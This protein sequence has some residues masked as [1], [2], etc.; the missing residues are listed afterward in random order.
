MTTIFPSIDMLSV[1]GLCCRTRSDLAI[2]G[3]QSLQGKMLIIDTNT[4]VQIF[5][6]DLNQEGTEG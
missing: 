4:N 6:I 1:L 3:F 2:M 5:N